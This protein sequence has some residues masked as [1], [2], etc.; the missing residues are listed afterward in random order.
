M[1]INFE[2][3]LNNALDDTKEETDILEIQDEDDETNPEVINSISIQPLLDQIANLKEKSTTYPERFAE[4]YQKFEEFEKHYP[5]YFIDIQNEFYKNQS[6]LKEQYLKDLLARENTKIEHAKNTLFSHFESIRNL[7]ENNKFKPAHDHLSKIN[8]EILQIPKSQTHLKNSLREEFHNILNLYYSTLD[9]KKDEL[10]QQ[11]VDSIKYIINQKNL[12]F[13]TINRVELDELLNDVQVLFLKKRIEFDTDLSMYLNKMRL[14]NS[15]VL[16][17]RNNIQKKCE[18]EFI[19]YFNYLEQQFRI[20]ISNNELYTSLIVLEIAHLLL[21]KETVYNQEL[22]ITYFLRL[23]E[24]KKEIN[25]LSFSQ[26][27]AFNEVELDLS[28]AYSQLNL[29]K[30][31]QNS[32]IRYSKS[33]IEQ[34]IKNISNLEHLTNEHKQNIIEKLRKK[35]MVENLDQGGRK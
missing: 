14:F 31:I 29:V 10:K 1:A 27:K 18:E 6:I 19:K 20:K 8:Y 12:V 22:K 30:L 28:Y 26:K 5:H 15:K 24:C 9:S 35:I 23:L 32:F 21:K 16:E 13:S 11:M 2:E 34:V 33:E 17:H 25:T 3:F 4:I 7:I